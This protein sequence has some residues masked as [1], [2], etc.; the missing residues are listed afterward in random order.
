M[1]MCIPSL[2]YGNTD[3]GQIRG[4]ENV[5]DNSVLESDPCNH[6]NRRLS[7]EDAYKVSALYKVA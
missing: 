6:E 3:K 5:G 7:H 1:V 2:F 4:R